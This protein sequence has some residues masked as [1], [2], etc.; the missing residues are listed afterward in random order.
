M[1]IR[2]EEKNK[3]IEFQRSGN[4]TYSINIR[5]KELH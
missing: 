4:I 1:F 3:V 2:N 5:L